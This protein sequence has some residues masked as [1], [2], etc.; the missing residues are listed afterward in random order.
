ML[1]TWKRS[2]TWC[3]VSSPVLRPLQITEAGGVPQRVPLPAFCGCTQILPLSLPP[4]RSPLAVR[5]RPSRLKGVLSRPA[6]PARGPR[7]AAQHKAAAVR[8]GIWLCNSWQGHTLSS[9][10]HQAQTDEVVFPRTQVSIYSILYRL[11]RSQT[12]GSQLPVSS[13]RRENTG[14][15]AKDS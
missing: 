9:S 6:V 3:L 7:S 13:S 4:G 5:A 10:E 11:S 1:K 14:A 8:E 12:P 2:G 15:E